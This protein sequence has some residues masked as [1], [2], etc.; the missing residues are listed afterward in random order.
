MVSQFSIL[1]VEDTVSAFEQVQVLLADQ[2]YCLHHANSAQQALSWLDSV[3][4]DLIL[5]ATDLK[6]VDSAALCARV[7]A[8]PLWA[9]LPI[10]VMMP[11]L[12]ELHTLSKMLLAGADEDR[13][14]VV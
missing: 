1:V 3:R 9:S 13:K 8:M 11:P 7:R 4:I 10:T 12:T 14:S 6:T 2:G 5:L